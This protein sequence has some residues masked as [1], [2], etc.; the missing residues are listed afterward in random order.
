MAYLHF[1]YKPN[2]TILFISDHFFCNSKK[3]R[4][5]FK[6]EHTLNLESCNVK[7]V[8]VVIAIIFI[9]KE[10]SNCYSNDALF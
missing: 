5:N 8:F 4:Y 3:K 7:F 2:I 10:E 1:I 6:K 9:L